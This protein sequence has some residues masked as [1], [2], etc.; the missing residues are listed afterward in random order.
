MVFSSFTFLFRFLPCFLVVYMVCPAKWKNLVL[1]AGSLAFYF[2]GVRKTPMY[3]ILFLISLLLNWYLGAWMVQAADE[4]HR[5]QRLFAGVLFN[6]CPLMVFKYSG[7]FTG[8]GLLLP[9]GISFYTF[10]MIGW[11]VDLYRREIRVFP[12]FLHF[13]TWAS[14][15]PHM[16]SGPILRWKY[17][18]TDLGA[19]RVT[20]SD[21][22]EALREL[23]IGLAMKVLLAN[24]LSGLW[25]KVGTIGY[26]SIST[27]FAWLG[28]IA[29]TF[30]I[31]FDFYG[32]SLMAVGLGRLLGFHLPENFHYPY[33]ACSM[34]EFWRRWHMTL[35]SWFRDY[36][37]IPLGG[38]RCSR[39]KLLRNL[40][41]VWLLTGIWHGAGW[42]FLLWG[43]C[44]FVMIAAEK[45]L[46]LKILNRYPW[47][48]HLYMMILIPLSWLPFAVA[49]IRNIVVYLERLFPFF[50][51]PG[52]YTWYAGDY[53]KYGQM[54]VWPLLAGLIF[55]TP[56][57]RKI[58]EK[59]KGSLISAVA[60]LMLFWFSIYCIHMGQDDPFLYFS[61]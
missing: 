4:K 47:L 52:A 28:L 22:E 49:E 32:Y 38:S 56:W 6:L 51:A 46:Y 26:E 15:W 54:Y 18:E 45:F 40:L 11:L 39:W 2:Y 33:M 21:V 53:L 59:Y 5:K 42:N 19:R 35:G 9:L 29:F 1:F 10:Q 61:F 31:Y 7:F 17:T 14:M 12:S 8:R 58:Y 44:L 3:L 55:I 36:V 37:Y 50:N 23:T 24:Q 48:G 34:T 30:Q 41:V 13:G 60:L 43:G 57:P 20:A 27:P 16:S 25:Q